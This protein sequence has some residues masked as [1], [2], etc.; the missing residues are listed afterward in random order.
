M[1]T[2]INTLIEVHEEDG[3]FIARDLLS[4]VADFGETK[5]TAVQMLLKG[6]KERYE[7]MIEDNIKMF[8]SAISPVEIE[9]E[10][11]D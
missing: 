6:L 5:E 9:V 3:Q 2:K 8:H 1:I 11:H 10:M 7:A 4:G